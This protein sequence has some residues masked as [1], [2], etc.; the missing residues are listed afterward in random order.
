[1]GWALVGALA[2][3]TLGLAVLDIPPEFPPLAGAGPTVFFTVASGVVAVLVF[4]ALRRTS[5]NYVRLFRWIAV[6]VLLL[7]FVPDL[8]LLSG[9]AA[10]AF[11]GAT[12]AGVGLLMAM[13]V[14]AA[15]GI[16]WPLT[17]GE[18]RRS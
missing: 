17:K 8:W 7:S 4:G 13:H 11:P 15:C 16:V 14:A 12:P 3:R 1:M 5:E 9:G 18:P 2:V 6:G 10:E